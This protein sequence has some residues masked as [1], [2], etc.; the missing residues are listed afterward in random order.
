[1]EDEIARHGFLTF[2]FVEAADAKAAEIEAVAM[3]RNVERL[4]ELVQN[5]PDDPPIMDVTEIEE[6]ESFGG[7]DE[8]EPGFIWYKE[9]PRRWWQFW[10]K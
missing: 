9:V 6:M 1:M 5:A 7:H 4:R 2:R 3:V 10:K 8:G